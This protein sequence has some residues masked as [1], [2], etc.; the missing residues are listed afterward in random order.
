MALKTKK[1]LI[2]TPTE[3]TRY[4]GDFRGVDFSS[5]QTEV[6]EQRF[7]YAV[8]MYRDYR[9]SEGNVIE[10]IPGFR[11]VID[12]SSMHLGDQIM[13]T[14]KSVFGAYLWKEHLFLHMGYSLYAI[15]K[16]ASTMGVTKQFSFILNENYSVLFPEN[17][18]VCDVV[19]VEAGGVIY[20]S[21]YTV[22]ETG[23]TFDN[24]N[25]VWS[26]YIGSS[27]LVNYKEDELLK[28]RIYYGLLQNRSSFI[29]FY[30]TLL[31]FDGNG[32]HKVLFSNGKFSFNSSVEMYV[33]TIYLDIGASDAINM[34]D[35]NRR[36]K[37]L[38]DINGLRDLLK[39]RTQLQ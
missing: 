20:K 8:N 33:P 4:Y 17:I 15:P 26:N 38:D 29:S 39:I 6:H 32:V 21:D 24:S 7:A 28:Y 25:G 5:E 27:V 10:T 12:N 22:S 11:R 16:G 35:F 23:I 30:N 37:Y 19:S 31:V 2:K 18:A 13:K 14:R 34:L 36:D 9:N 1:N 3:Y